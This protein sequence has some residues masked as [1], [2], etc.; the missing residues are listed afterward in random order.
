M[1]NRQAKP[2]Y[3]VAVLLKS[4]ELKSTWCVFARQIEKWHLHVAI[5]ILL[6]GCCTRFSWT[7]IKWYSQLA[8]IMI[9][10]WYP[11]NEWTA[12]P[13]YEVHV[14]N[15]YSSADTSFQVFQ[16]KN[17]IVLNFFIFIKYVVS[18]L[19]LHSLN[20]NFLW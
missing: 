3:R 7:L 16:K 6:L 18:L 1:T 9:L 2:S 19:L 15:M 5:D 17:S 20:W 12:W 4:D 10:A 13:I 8:E 11:S 14:R